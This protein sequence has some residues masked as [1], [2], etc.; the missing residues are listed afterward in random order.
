MVDA[1]TSA[2]TSSTASIVKTL[3]S[4]SG[5]DTGAIVDALVQAQYAA[6]NSALTKQADTLTAQISGVAKLKSGITGL[7]TA[8]R[9]LVRGGSLTTQPTSGNAAV[10][11]V[12]GAGTAGLSGT[13]TVNRLATAQAATTDTPVGAG[14]RF[15]AGT[16][17]ITT[18]GTTTPI[19]IAATDTLAG[20]AAKINAAG[21][22]L[23]AT[24]V[25]DGSGVRMTVKGT[26]GA[27]NAFTIDGADDDATAPGIGLAGLSVGAGA[28]GTTIGTAAADAELVLDGATF[29]RA[30]NGV[31]D[32]LPGVRLDLKSA[33]T[34]TL[35]TTPPTAALSQAVGDL[36]ETLNQLHAVVATALDPKTGVLRADPAAAALSRA[37]AGLTTVS[38]AANA[39]GAPRTLGDIGV[40]TNRDGTLSI[41]ATQLA[42]V[43]ADDP[44]AV[45]AMFADGA[46]ASNGGISAAL[47]AINARATDRLY[48]FDAETT[49]FT[50]RQGDVT[51]AQARAT[52]A[53]AALKD[54]LTQQ[55]A[56]MDSRVAAYKSTQDFLKQQ[57]D[58]WNKSN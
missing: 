2:T 34:T 13:L 5:L 31:T 8:L 6:K 11:T 26:T 30:T 22:G 27:A 44:G 24:L 7:D 32:L 10:A 46:G 29:H 58:A 16:L 14:D 4:G 50:A 54:R 9:T 39:D 18:G 55:F 35:G 52:D 37:L 48:G 36:V 40:R 3:G 12:S 28:T 38:L 47:G 19:T 53:A 56:T 42:K 23:T 15:R 25:G 33:G 1:T 21:L 51:D 49:R 41:D 43:L 45:E 57:V 20:V 17:A